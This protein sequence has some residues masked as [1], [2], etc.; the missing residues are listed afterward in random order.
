LTAHLD[1]IEMLALVALRLQKVK[2]Q[3]VFVGGATVSLYV[4]DPGARLARPT[5]DVDALVRCDTYHAYQEIGEALLKPCGL[6]PD[7]EAGA[8]ICRWRLKPEGIRL[9]VMPTNPQALG[10]RGRWLLAAFENTQAQPIGPDQEIRITQAPFLVAMKFEAFRDRGRSDYYGSI[11]LEDIITV[12]DGRTELEDEISKVGGELQSYLRVEFQR[13]LDDP[14]F[15]S[16]FPGH[17]PLEEVTGNRAG[18][19]LRRLNRLAGR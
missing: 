15:Q 6:V 14:G 17:L 18:P 4:T 8:P 9:D 16:A 19:L 3:L 5:K 2:D 10:F 1:P 11:D 12:V 13:L 7:T